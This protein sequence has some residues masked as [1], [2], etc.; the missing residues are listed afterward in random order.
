MARDSKE[1]WV[2]VKGC[3]VV[4]DQDGKLTSNKE[5]VIKVWENYLMELYNQGPCHPGVMGTCAS[6]DK[7]F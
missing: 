3:R 6:M 2:Y 1:E 7:H 5:E 4:R